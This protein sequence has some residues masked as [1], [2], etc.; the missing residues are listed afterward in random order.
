MKRKDNLKI[1]LLNL[2]PKDL[3]SDKD[4]DHFSD[5]IENYF[6]DEDEMEKEVGK[7]PKNT[8]KPTPGVVETQ[9]F[10]HPLP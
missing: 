8:S 6:L 1:A 7:D 3:D 4:E 10:V 5:D 2:L 9:D